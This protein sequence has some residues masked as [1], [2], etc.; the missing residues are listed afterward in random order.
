MVE[1]MKKVLL[2]LFCLLVSSSSIFAGRNSR[3]SKSP[4]FR[5]SDRQLVRYRD[6]Q[7]GDSRERVER[8]YHTELGNIAR[9][10]DEELKT[11]AQVYLVKSLLKVV[12]R[13]KNRQDI[14]LKD[15][16]ERTLDN[17]YLLAQ[18]KS[19]GSSYPALMVNN[20][21]LPQNR[22]LHSKLNDERGTAWFVKQL[23][24]GKKLLGDVKSPII[25]EQGPT[26][27]VDS[28]NDNTEDELS[29]TSLP[30]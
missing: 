17:H 7:L 27:D 28:D 16:L 14:D 22:E 6:Y 24:I 11:R 1:K 5:M 25:M 29:P 13:N 19:K 15:E 9:D 12:K 20:Y 8:C 30:S 3:R 23:K 4:L 18:F 21:Y 10:D 2:A 26:V